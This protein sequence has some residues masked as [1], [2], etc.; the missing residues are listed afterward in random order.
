MAEK[1]GI[2]IVVLGGGFGG[3]YTVQNLQRQLHKQKNCTV[4]L[5]DKQN[6]FLFTPLMHEVATGGISFVSTL[7]PLRDL[8]DKSITEFCLGNVN[9]ILLKKQLVETTE[10]TLA[11]DYLAIAL[12]SETNYYNI[13]GAKEFTFALRSFEDAFVLKNHLIETFEQSSCIE[14]EEMLQRKLTFVIIG[15]GP[16]GVELAGEIS[17]FL[18]GTFAN[19]Y[20]K[21]LL[22]KAR[23]IL[24]QKGPELLPQLAPAL[25]RYTLTILKKKHIDVRLN[26]KVMQVNKYAVELTGG[27]SIPTETAIWVAGVKPS[28]VTIEGNVLRDNTGRLLVE[29][30]GQLQNYP[31]VFVIGDFAHMENPKDGKTVPALAQA[32]TNIAPQV[33]KNICLL[34]HK[35]KPNPITYTHKGDLLSIGKWYAIGKIGPIKIFGVVTWWFWRTVYFFY[36]PSFKKKLRVSFDWMI[37]F[38]FPRDISQFGKK[39]RH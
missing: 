9:T 1:K 11:Y 10:K 4:T 13:P 18:Y 25:R 19:Y 32:A 26:M 31:N 2:N 22:A 20:E 14:D 28:T 16:T 36:M 34:M 21:R 35:Q 30:T 12:G 23:I 5:I 38:F 33:A 24:L 6:Y 3:I 8:L 37:E 15:G 29:N 7:I 27:E 39:Q 17:D